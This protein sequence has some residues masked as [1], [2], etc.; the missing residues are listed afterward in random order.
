MPTIHAFGP[1]RL[2]ADAKILFRGAEPV[3]LGRRAVALLQVLVERAGAPVSKDA[4][5]EAAWPGLAVE[6]SNLTVQIAALRRVFE[7]EPSGERWIETLPR[8]GYRF[9]GPAVAVEQNDLSASAPKAEAPT[10]PLPDKPS[11]AVLPFHNLS[12]DPEQEYF[13]DGVVEDVIAALSRMRWLFVIARNSSFA[14]KG[15]AIDVKQVGRELGVRYVLEGGL[16]KSGNRIRITAQL[17]DATVGTHLW[18]DR[19]E[20][21][22]DDIFELQDQLAASVVGA[23]APKLEQAEIERA[24]HK[25]TDSLDAYDYFLRGMASFYRRTPDANGEALRLFLRA[26]ELDPDFA[27]AYGMAAWCC[28]WRK[29]NGW[30]T[31]YTRE[32]TEAAQLARPCR[33][34]GQGRRG[35]ACEGWARS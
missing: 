26:I 14:Y 20:G 34:I 2:D 24:K 3:A 10:L 7:E 11:I 4:L 31:D 19:F 12:G 35:S 9:A 16:R 6:E 22:L 23:I 33:G 1:F 25:P 17:I 8:R 32:I 15:R 28:V 13:A 5:I 27:S 21:S 30:I 29:L 18:A